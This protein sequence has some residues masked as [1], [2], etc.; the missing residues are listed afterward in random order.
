MT[1]RTR[2][3]PS[4]AQ[5]H[6]RCSLTEESNFF[7]SRILLWAELCTPVQDARTR[8]CGW[9]ILS[10]PDPRTRS[11]EVVVITGS[12]IRSISVLDSMAG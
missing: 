4:A 12:R 3:L 5:A 2:H 9:P 11:A 6:S 7:E 8:R 10:L 1:G